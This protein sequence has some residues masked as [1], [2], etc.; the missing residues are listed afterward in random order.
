MT[1]KIIRV[2][3][4]KILGWLWFLFGGVWDVVAIS[5]LLSCEASIIPQKSGYSEGAWWDEVI[6]NI[7]EV[8]SSLARAKLRTIGFVLIG[9]AILCLIVKVLGK[10]DVMRLTL[11]ILNVIASVGL[12]FLG[13]FAVAAHRTHAYSVYRELQEQHVLVERDDDDVERRLHSIAGGGTYSA[14]IAWIGAGI[15]LANAAAIGFLCGRQKHD[16]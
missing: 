12:V 11:V 1:V 14:T 13:S 7:T 10:P 6:K 3:H 5:A 4:V 8:R 16:G 15:C 2:Q 9:V